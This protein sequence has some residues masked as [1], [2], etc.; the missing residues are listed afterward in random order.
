MKIYVSEYIKSFISFLLLVEFG[1]LLNLW[2]MVYENKAVYS[3]V[4]FKIGVQKKNQL[5]QSK[6][7]LAAKNRQFSK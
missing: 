7:L 1:I 2:T 3:V 6:M 5:Y 4:C